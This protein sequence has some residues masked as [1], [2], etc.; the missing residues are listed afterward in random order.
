MT[1]QLTIKEAKKFFF[2]EKKIRRSVAKA[3]RR[4]RASR[5]AGAL[6]RRDARS[7]MRKVKKRTTVASPG[8]PPRAH[9][10]E[11]N[12]RTIFYVFDPASMSTVVGPPLFRSSK[13]A[14]DSLPVPGLHEHGG[15][16]YRKRRVYGDVARGADG[17]VIGRKFTKKRGPVKLAKRPYMDPALEKNREKFP[18]LWR[19]SVR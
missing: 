10:S 4:L 18:A 19:D 12:L 14:K 9:S 3:R 17:E 8:Q 13:N 1:L 5:R 15:T 16:A 11:P 7:S 2:D 6:V